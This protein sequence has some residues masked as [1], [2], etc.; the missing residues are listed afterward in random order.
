MAKSTPQAT[1][2]EADDTLDMAS[3]AVASMIPQA[4]AAVSGTPGP[5]ENVDQVQVR[6]IRP[7]LPPPTVIADPAIGKQVKQNKDST[8]KHGIQVPLKADSL[9][10]AT[11]NKEP[12]GMISSE[13]DP[14][15]DVEMIDLVE[16]VC[17]PPK[18]KEEDM[19]DKYA[20]DLEGKAYDHH[21]PQPLTNTTFLY[22]GRLHPQTA[23]LMEHC[24]EAEA[25]DEIDI[26]PPLTPH[27][28]ELNPETKTWDGRKA[29]ECV[30][31][32][33]LPGWKIQ[34][35]TASV[36]AQHQQMEASPVDEA[37]VD[38]S[39]EKKVPKK[40]KP[41]LR[42]V[43]LTPENMS[44]IPYDPTALRVVAKRSTKVTKNWFL[45][46]LLNPD[47]ATKLCQGWRVKI[48][49][50]FY[51][52]AFRGDEDTGYLLRKQATQEKIRA[53]IFYKEPSSS[54]H[55]SRS[56]QSDNSPSTPSTGQPPKILNRPASKKTV[57]AVEADSEFHAMVD[58]MMRNLKRAE[59]KIN[60]EKAVKT[61]K[62]GAKRKRVSFQGDDKDIAD[63][64]DNTINSPSN[65][66]SADEDLEAKAKS[67]A[68]QH[69]IDRITTMMM[70]LVLKMS[71]NKDLAALTQG[72]KMLKCM[73][74]RCLP[75]DTSALGL[76]LNVP[77]GEDGDPP[78]C[79]VKLREL[80]V[81]LPQGSFPHLVSIS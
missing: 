40:A 72:Y 66:S 70:N 80:L 45:Y 31:V 5:Q 53:L 73:E 65:S 21:I 34:K 3:Q 38:G 64:I 52:K 11:K 6:S 44:S 56:K 26:C 7:C 18:A 36:V 14:E 9:K 48:D 32:G 43:D 15:S 35:K 46:A 19:F 28:N 23:N 61:K 60:N 67:L 54:A 12:Q 49:E 25:K 33:M 57:N 74:Q 41:A 17:P 30:W 1:G 59:S 42:I 76:Y 63:T 2:P 27:K 50:V 79:A 10:V 51:F 58:I 78:A 47:P 81:S 24:Q 75:L 55:L 29:I 39:A 68:S 37:Q 8:K 22:I 71:N 77:P 62:T 4:A 16:G 69:N 13:A 20:F